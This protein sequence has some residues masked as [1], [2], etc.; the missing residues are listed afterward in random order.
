MPCLERRALI[1]HTCISVHRIVCLATESSAW[2]A[3]LPARSTVPH[4]EE[5]LDDLESTIKGSLLILA[6][7][8]L[9]LDLVSLKVPRLAHIFLYYEIIYAMGAHCVPATNATDADFRI[10]I[11]LGLTSLSLF[12]DPLA[13]LLF[14][15]VGLLLST[16]GQPALTYGKHASMEA[17][18]TLDNLGLIA[19]V[20]CLFIQANLLVVSLATNN[21]K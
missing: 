7:M 4:N 17:G 9:V 5:M 1:L 21:S 6:A 15:T 10:I 8:S 11:R 14:L 13:N 16:F 19:V 18:H 3:D 12:C 2:Q 20:L